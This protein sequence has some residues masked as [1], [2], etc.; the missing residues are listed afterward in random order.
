MVVE[1]LRLDSGLRRP[2]V[3]EHDVAYQDEVGGVEQGYYLG[4]PDR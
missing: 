2:V 1:G 4:S 3:V